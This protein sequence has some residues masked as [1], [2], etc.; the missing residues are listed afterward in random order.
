M[1]KWFIM[2]VDRTG[3]NVISKYVSSVTQQDLKN[4]KIGIYKA[5]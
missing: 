2:L 3:I 5:D 4:E 1:V